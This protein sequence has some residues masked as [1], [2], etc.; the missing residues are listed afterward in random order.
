MTI[1]L[2]PENLNGFFTFLVLVVDLLLMVIA[3]GVRKK[4]GYRAAA[5]FGLVA[6]CV[7]VLIVFDA[8]SEYV[9]DPMHVLSHSI[10]GAIL[11]LC[12]KL[13]ATER[14]PPILDRLVFLE[15]NIFDR[16]QYS[17]ARTMMSL[18][19]R[20]RDSLEFH[21]FDKSQYDLVRIVVSLG[22]NVRKIQT[23]SLN[24]NMMSFLFGFIACLLLLRCFV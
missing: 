16:F 9:L 13:L 12:A 15:L 17:L 4:I 21:V 23:G 24:L 1:R 2:A 11:L 8:L 7:A 18:F 14:A 20:T 22:S 5:T 3:V 19:H 6:T 10:F